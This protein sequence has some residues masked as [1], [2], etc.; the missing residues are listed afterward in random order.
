MLDRLSG[1]GLV[2][3]RPCSKINLD[4]PPEAAMERLKSSM[5]LSGNDIA[6]GIRFHLF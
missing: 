4:G 3:R 1:D 2:A 5:Q 6:L